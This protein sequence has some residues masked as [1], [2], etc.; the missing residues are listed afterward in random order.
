MAVAARDR[1]QIQQNVVKIVR[2]W[3]RFIKTAKWSV[4]VQGANI[5]LR[6]NLVKQRVGSELRL[7]QETNFLFFSFRYFKLGCLPDSVIQAGGFAAL[8][9][10][11][12][13]VK[14]G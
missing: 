5:V 6:A 14:T 10:R 13:N 1:F 11:E 3:G 9:C 8:C 12:C 2:G 4:P 7:W